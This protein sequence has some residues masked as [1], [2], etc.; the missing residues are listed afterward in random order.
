MSAV[1]SSNIHLSTSSQAAAAMLAKV[2][3]IAQGPLAAIA[4]QIDRQGTY[5]AKVLKDLGKAGLYRAQTGLAGTPDLTSAIQGV[6][7]VS[8]VCGATGFM[9]WCQAACAALHGAQR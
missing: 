8:K 6:A 9:V 1:A 2:Q 7:E 5:P 3:A 4:D